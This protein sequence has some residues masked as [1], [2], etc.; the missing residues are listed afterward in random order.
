[1]VAT[2]ITQ[3]KAILQWTAADGAAGYKLR[4]KVKNTSSWTVLASHDN[5]KKISGLV[6]G[7]TYVWQ[8]KTICS[9]AP[10]VASEWSAKKEFTTSLRLGTFSEPPGS[11]SVYPNPVTTEAI[12][13][14]WIAENSG[15]TLELFDVSGKKVQT[16]LATNLE[17]GNHEVLLRRNQLTPGIYLLG[18]TAGEKTE[19]VKIPIE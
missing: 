1:M 15:A 7:T 12:I 14:L 19:V 2:G 11:L 9:T 8:V 10:I 17:A 18:F 4:Y 6:T 3:S 16:L 13:R 5:S